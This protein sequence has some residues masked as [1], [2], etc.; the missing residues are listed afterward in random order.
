MRKLDE[1]M[2]EADK[3]PLEEQLELAQHL[4]A[5]AKRTKYAAKTVD[6]NKFAGRVKLTEDPLQYQKR[7]RAEWP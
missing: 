6:L 3:L 7:V 1:I 2:N 5:H 4:I